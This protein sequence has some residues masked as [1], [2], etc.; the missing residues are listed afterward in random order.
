VVLAAGYA[1]SGI[2]IGGIARRNLRHVGGKRRRTVT[3]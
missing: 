2:W 3:G 1:V